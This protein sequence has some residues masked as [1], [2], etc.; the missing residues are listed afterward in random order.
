MKQKLSVDEQ[1]EYMSS[2]KGIKFE[3]CEKFYAKEFLSYHSYY[4]KLKAYDKCFETY[5]NPKHP[6]YGQYVS[7]DFK[8][9][10]ILSKI[11]MAF[12]HILLDLSLEIEHSLKVFL[13]HLISEASTEDG[14]TVVEQFLQNNDK[15]KSK[16]ENIISHPN[17]NPYTIDMVKKYKDN[18]AIWNLIEILTFGDLLHFWNFYMSNQEVKIKQSS[19][20]IYVKYIRNASAHLNCMLNQLSYSKNG[21][22]VKPSKLLKNLISQ[23]LFNGKKISDS[24]DRLLEVPVLHD[25]AACIFVFISFVKSD[26]AFER[27]KENLLSFADLVKKYRYIFNNELNLQSG[28]D[29]ILKLIDFMTT[30]KI[31]KKS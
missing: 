21:F 19:L 25:F 20:I 22:K 9:L 1:I 7:L 6:K 4:F 13:N 28:F 23:N 24:W 17:S 14:Y 5:N 2:Q 27:T 3:Q 30:I 26:N 29:Y 15:I 10:L 16:I 8:Q 12:R 18:F 11:D 31:C